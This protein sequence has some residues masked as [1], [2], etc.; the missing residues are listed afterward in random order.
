[1]SESNDHTSYVND[2]EHIEASG[3]DPVLDPIWDILFTAMAMRDRLGHDE[4]V[5]RLKQL[6]CTWFDNDTIDGHAIYYLEQLL[7]N[8][9]L[10]V[11]SLLLVGEAVG[12]LSVVWGGGDLADTARAIFRAMH[13]IDSRDASG[14]P[15]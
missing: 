15:V 4:I 2:E 7:D 3:T 11:D 1:M 14:G 6:L 5:R 9:D 13:A 12:S 8:T 10:A